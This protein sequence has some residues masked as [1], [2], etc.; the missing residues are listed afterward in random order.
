MKLLDFKILNTAIEREINRRVGD[1]NITY[2][3]GSVLGFLYNCSEGNVCQKDIE[4]YLGL[5]HPTVSSILSRLEEKGLVRIET[6][7]N[8][9]RVK[10][11]LATES[12]LELHNR[13]F[14]EIKVIEK[15]IMTG[16]TREEKDSVD[17]AV[18]KMI[19][20]LAN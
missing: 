14:A 3:Q 8:D 12:G 17:R 19:R 16:L 1:L 6:N 7:K 13:I 11:V 10:N 20:N 4:F 15:Q 18:Q 9:R 5:A 2:A